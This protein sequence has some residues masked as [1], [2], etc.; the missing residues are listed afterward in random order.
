[1]SDQFVA[2]LKHCPMSAQKLREMRKNVCGKRAAL[3]VAVL[4][5]TQ[6][7]SAYFMNKVLNS[8]IANA[9]QNH[10]ADVD[11]LYV[12]TIEINEAPT[13]KRGQP[14]AKGRSYPILKRRCH[15]TITLSEMTNS[16]KVRK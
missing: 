6:K 1:M 4:G 13:L 3:A 9:D 15:I 8:A 5:A 10:G 14:R 16:T 2:T 11:A 7:R 12:K